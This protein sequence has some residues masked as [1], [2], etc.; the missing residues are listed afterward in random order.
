[1]T[2]NKEIIKNETAT[3]FKNYI[4]FGMPRVSTSVV[5][6]IV[7]FGILFLYF[8]GYGLSSLFVGISAMVGK[9][10]IAFSQSYLGWLSDKTKTKFGKRKPYMIIG[11]PILAISFIFLLL[12]TIFL[13]PNPADALLFMWL[14]IWDVM[15]Q[16]FYGITT[17][18]QSWMAEQ[19]KVNERPTASAFQNIFNYLGTGIALLSV[20]VLPK[21]L[22]D[23]QKTRIINPLFIGDLFIFAAL[24]ISLFYI[25]AF[26]LPVEK[27]PPVRMNLRKDLQMIIKDRNFIH[28]CMMVGI[29]SL[30]WSM[31]TGIMLGYVNKVLKITNMF[32]G[33]GALA[34][35]V[36]G[37]LFIWKTII[38]KIGKKKAL[39]LIFIWAI[40]ALP[41]GAIIPLLPFEDFTIPTVVLV[42]IISSALGG[43]F[44]FPYIL[45][46]DLAENN[47]KTGEKSELKS[48][49]YNGFPSILLNI[50]QGVGWLLIGSILLLPDAPSRDYSWGYLLWAPIGSIILIVAL[51]YL[52]KFI[53]LDFDWEKKRKVD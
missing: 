31:I 25:S 42:L 39:I 18:Y 15:F 27:A 3:P 26:L 14:L 4:F 19:F 35:G 30:C 53:T 40:C 17:P 45:Y 22:A 10:A 13:G 44:L 7:D 36:V 20:M 46:S 48:G 38:G 23:F 12:P 29:A 11:A 49:L 51:L 8:E 43:W 6:T 52:K 37:S 24:V 41:F 50:F 9:F 33:A 21:I 5:L 16:F 2:E 34:I 28:V 47:E 32:F 1:M